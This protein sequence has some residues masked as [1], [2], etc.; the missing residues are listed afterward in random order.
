MYPGRLS[1]RY[2]IDEG[3]EP[4]QI[5]YGIAENRKCVGKGGEPDYSRAAALLIDDFRSGALGR[6]TLEMPE[7]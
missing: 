2:A 4:V 7:E 3:A 5:L 1:E 6:I